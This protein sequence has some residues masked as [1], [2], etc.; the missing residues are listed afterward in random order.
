MENVPGEDFW[1]LR[2]E[3]LG[4]LREPDVDE[5]AERG[6]MRGGVEG[7]EL[8]AVPVDLADVEVLSDFC[9]FGGGDVV[10]GA[11]DALCGLV[12]RLCVR[13]RVA[14]ISSRGAHVVG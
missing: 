5:A 4:I 8:D 13:L 9:D 10:C 3:E 7:R 14:M 12:L 6:A 11:P 2:T 1:I